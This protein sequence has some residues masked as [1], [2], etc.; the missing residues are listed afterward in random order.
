MSV[1]LEYTPL[2][3]FIQDQSDTVS[4]FSSS[5]LYNRKKVTKWL[6]DMDYIFTHL[7]QSFIMLF[8]LL[9]NKKHI[10]IPPCNIRYVTFG[11]HTAHVDCPDILYCP[12]GQATGVLDG[13]KHECP[14]SQALQVTAPVS[15]A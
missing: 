1:L 3:K 14:A 15:L 12:A 7:L 8:L 10:F 9:A 11:I 4:H 6:E 13:F 5:C 2:G